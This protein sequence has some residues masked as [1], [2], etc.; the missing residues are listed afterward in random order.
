[1]PLTSHV[2]KH[3]N[4]VAGAKNCSHSHR[5][6]LMV[7]HNAIKRGIIATAS[8][9]A[10]ADGALCSDEI[11]SILASHFQHIALAESPNGAVRNRK[12]SKNHH[13]ESTFESQKPVRVLDLGSGRGGDLHKWHHANASEYVGVDVS[14][15]SCEEALRRAAFCRGMK[16]K[17]LNNSVAEFF[18]AEQEH[19][20]APVG[21]FNVI[22]LQFVLNYVVDSH[23]ALAQLF[24]SCVRCLRPGG[25]IVGTTV[26]DA[27]AR[28]YMDA[29]DHS[30]YFSL[31]SVPG[32]EMS[33]SDIGYLYQFYL[34]NC[35]FSCIECI[36]PWRA[37][38]D[39]AT[40][41]GLQLDYMAGFA[42]TVLDAGDLET[43]HDAQK[44]LTRL[45]VAFQFSQPERRKDQ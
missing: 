11:R 15:E 19:C 28:E 3:Y 9:C 32:Q 13:A 33:S 2:A 34:H 16:T 8:Q 12:P 24:E 14:Y 4:Q 40:S 25:V 35:V 27:V 7:R 45:Y 1:M 21:T 10:S 6:S 42:S 44:K 18:A 20:L 26:D 5:D 39:A 38:H 22:S 41:A 30:D 37:I 31:S 43:L 23:R 17:I 29:R 36:V